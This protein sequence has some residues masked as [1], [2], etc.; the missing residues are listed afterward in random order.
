MADLGLDVNQL[1]SDELPAGFTVSQDYLDNR[2]K[3]WQLLLW[4]AAKVP[5]ESMYDIEAYSDDWKV[6]LSYLIVYDVLQ[7]ILLGNFVTVLDTGTEDSGG[8]VKKIVTGPTEVEFHDTGKALAE[9]LKALSEGGLFAQFLATACAFANKLGIKL[10]FCAALKRPGCIS[11]LHNKFPHAG[12]N[13]L[14]RY[15][16]ENQPKSLG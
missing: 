10:P 16:Q 3:V 4:V 15:G 2:L 8:G 14:T 11:I 9:I 1:V 13:G 7:R 12:F 6:L 5:E